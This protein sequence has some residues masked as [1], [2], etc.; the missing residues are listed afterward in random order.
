M[1]NKNKQQRLEASQQKRA[2]GIEDEL[3]VTNF[4]PGKKIELMAVAENKGVTLSGLVRT[5][6][7]GYLDS[8][9]EHEKR[10]RRPD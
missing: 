5:V 3:A 4:Q 10:F 8:L 2:K 1:S 6:L 7:Y 9:P